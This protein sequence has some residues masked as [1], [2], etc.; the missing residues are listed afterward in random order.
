MENIILEVMN[1]KQEDI[2]KRQRENK[3]EWVKSRRDVVLIPRK[4]RRFVSQRVDEANE[5]EVDKTS[6][7][8]VP[9]ELESPD[10]QSNKTPPQ[11]LD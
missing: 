5:E 11:E 9:A 10:I 6:P 4:R 2:Q 3:K 1:L 7:H 8:C